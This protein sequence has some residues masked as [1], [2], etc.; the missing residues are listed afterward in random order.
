M[1]KISWDKETGGVRLHREVTP[2]T[3]G[4][5]PRPVFWE[6]LDL[7]KLHELGW[8]YPHAEEPLLWACNK[9]YYYRG[10]LIFEVK[11]ANI[12][13]PAV[14]TLAEGVHPGAL[15]PVD[16]AE[17]LRRNKDYLFLIESEAI[18]F[19]RD[20]YLQYS[21]ANRSTRRV[22]ANQLDYNALRERAEKRTKQ[23]MAIVKEDCDSFD[24]VPLS[25]ARETGKRV[26]HATKIDRFIA[27]FSGGK[28]SQVVLDLCVRAIPSTDFEVIYS[29]TGYEL[30]TSLKLYDEV[31]RHY[32]A[33][34]PDLKFSTARNHESVLRYW[35]QIGTPSDTHRWCCSVMKTAPLYRMLKVE[36]TNRQA[37]VL[38][39]DGVRAEESTRRSSYERIGKGVKHDTVINARPILYWNSAEI[40]LYLL[41][42][43]LP[44]NPAYRQGMTRVGCLLCP[45]ANEW[46]ERIAA[47]NYEKSVRPFLNRLESYAEL[48]GVKDIRNYIGS[49]GWKRRASGNL[50][51]QTSF[52]S[53]ET[54]PSA[55]TATIRNPKKNILVYLGT[56][57]EYTLNNDGK[58]NSL[59]G[60]IRISGKV[61][62]FQ[63]KSKETNISFT[64][65]G[66]T[67]A[68][69]VGLIK[70]VLYKGT[71]CIQCE[72]CEVE[73]PTGAL[74]VYPR[75][76]VD[77]QRCIHCHKCLTFH[78]KGC[79]VAN[80]LTITS[81]TMTNSKTP[82]IDC[83]RNFGLREEWLEDY[84][85]S[86]DNFWTSNHGLNE[87]YQIPS[88]K[89]WLR[90][91]ELIGRK[92]Q[93][94]ALARLLSAIS[95]NANE[96]P[97]LIWE[98]VWINLTYNSS[99]VNWFIRNI[100]PGEICTQ[101]IMTQQLSE[102]FPTYKEKTIGNALYQLRRLL[103]ESPI[104]SRMNQYQ[105][106]NKE[107]AYREADD[108]I[109]DEAVVYSIY[110]FARTI[111]TQT[112]R[113]ADVYNAA[114][115]HGVYKEFG[116]SEAEFEK[117]L[118]QLSN[119]SN[120]ILLAELNMGLDHITLREDL[121]ALGALKLA[122]GL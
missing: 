53:F 84:L 98:I 16:V 59:I 68:K 96:S 78:D 12:Y 27:S 88:L 33:L 103:R 5:A 28:D 111:G 77:A 23:P 107:E 116:L 62:T 120:R 24:I 37:K 8:T 74:T 63:L 61:Y 102:Q 60:E 108:S 104:G 22:A 65:K 20:T 106:V 75:V 56:I 49:G 69:L 4:I 21:A 67:D 47:V 57:G 46:N 97:N 110:K 6:E 31:R 34:Y 9:Q 105:V 121:D 29:D 51:D 114:A 94:T 2:D 41:R 44:V 17:M 52:I 81:T 112:L 3:L 91:A 25:S 1:Y 113:V 36:G 10:T 42:N 101:S 118:R 30:P 54:S 70:R 85:S 93:A 76:N 99:I 55:L 13:D 72:A 79:I 89:T 115:E 92:N 40:F 82:R 48:A 19:I 11:G 58:A 80:S 109:S 87:N 64:I 86:L 122:T 119:N 35:D 43:D 7:L 32:N 14:V 71:Y 66:I 45:F 50:I 100:K 90:D 39:F 95:P 73:C 117:R 83:Y 15:Q 18:E 26:Y 38:T